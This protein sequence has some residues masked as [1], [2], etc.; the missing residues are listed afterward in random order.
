MNESSSDKQ[1]FTLWNAERRW[2]RGG[3]IGV[4]L[5]RRLFGHNPL[6]ES[7]QFYYRI[8]IGNDV[9]TGKLDVDQ[10]IPSFDFASVQSSDRMVH[11]PDFD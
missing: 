10:L 2:K 1:Q 7:G 9:Q 4:A 6:E 5:I 8:L 3:F 11:R